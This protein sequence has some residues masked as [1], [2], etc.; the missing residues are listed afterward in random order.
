MKGSAAAIGVYGKGPIGV[1]GTGAVGGVF[2]GTDTALSLTPTG[3]SGPSTTQSLKGDVLVDKDG[4]MWFC[5]ARRHAR[6]VD[7]ALARRH[8]AA[9]RLPCARTRA[10]PGRGRDPAPGRA[11]DGSDPLRRLADTGRRGRRAREPHDPLDPRRRV[12][13]DLPRRS[14]GAAD[15]ERQLE[16]PARASRIANAVTV[17][18]GTDGSVTLF[19]DATVPP[20]SPATHVI[21]DIAAYVL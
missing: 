13:H 10:P 21:L 5:I 6:D 15:V 7:Q 19:T 11:A 16:R 9:R 4:V 12:P 14:S 2:A 20:G 1:L 18:L 3:T 17:G 8:A